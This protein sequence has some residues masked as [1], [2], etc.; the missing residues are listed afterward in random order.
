MLN[1]ELGEMIRRALAELPDAL[2]GPVTMRLVDDEPYA[3][4]SEM[5]R[6]SEANARK[7]IQQAREILQ[8]RLETYLYGGDRQV[9]TQRP[10]AA[11]RGQARNAGK[12]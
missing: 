2:R 10:V 11:R 12:S 1:Q 9:R 7:R 8:Q 5:F 4:I 6:I 3:L